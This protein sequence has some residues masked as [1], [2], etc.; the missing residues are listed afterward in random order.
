MVPKVSWRM[1]RDKTDPPHHH[2]SP[3]IVARSFARKVCAAEPPRRFLNQPAN[4]VAKILKIPQVHFLCALCRDAG[5]ALS[6]LWHLSESSDFSDR[7]SRCGEVEL[8]VESLICSVRAPGT[9]FRRKPG[10]GN[11]ESLGCFAAT[12]VREKL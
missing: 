9:K 3:Y 7:L 11:R 12:P 1:V 8:E 6:E 5:D 4:M 10:S 2:H